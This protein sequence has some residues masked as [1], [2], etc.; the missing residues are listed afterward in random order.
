MKNNKF[1][2]YDTAGNKK[3]LL[4]IVLAF[5][6]VIN[7]AI[8]SICIGAYFISVPEVFNIILSK[9]RGLSIPQL[10]ESIIFNIRITRILIAL[11]VGVALASSGAVF[12]GIFHNPLI[13]PY[14]LGVSSGAAFGA[15]LAVITKLHG[16]IQIFAFI[17]GLIAVILTYFISKKSG[18]TGLITLILSGM[19]VS[20]VFSGLVSYIQYTGNEEQLK[21]LVFWLMGGLYRS[22]WRDVHITIPIIILGIIIYIFNSWKLNVLST[23]ESDARA[24]GISVEKLKIILLLTATCLTSVAV[25]VS[26]IIGWIGLMIPH[27]ARMLVGS[28]NRYLIPMSALMGAG[29]LIICDTLSRTI[30]S[31]EIPISIISSILGAP[32]MIYLIRK[33]AIMGG[34]M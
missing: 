16:L 32:Y 2:S 17:F 21:V 25:S 10:E 8:L 24:L 20:S 15:G 12:Q 26:G 3:K 13:E 30:S 34:V 27:A 29:F 7:I 31:G 22:T 33:Y 6:F 28:D 19:V 5:I 14:V 18:K 11:T 23:G 9:L 1:V 4:L